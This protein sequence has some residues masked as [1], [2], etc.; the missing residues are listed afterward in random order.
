[1]TSDDLRIFSGTFYH[2]M[3]RASPV[4]QRLR[5][6]SIKK[7]RANRYFIYFSVNCVTRAHPD[8]S[9]RTEVKSHHMSMN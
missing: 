4:A 3:V 6:F 9:R 1:M 7:L 5:Q 2:G 8:I